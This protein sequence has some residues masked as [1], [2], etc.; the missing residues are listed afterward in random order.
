MCLER[1]I[2]RNKKNAL[3]TPNAREPHFFPSVTCSKAGGASPPHRCHLPPEF[4]PL[5]PAKDPTAP[6]L[7]Y[8][9]PVQQTTYDPC[10]TLLPG[11]LPSLSLG[12]LPYPASRPCLLAT[13]VAD[14]KRRQ[15]FDGGAQESEEA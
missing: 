11:L 9:E 2:L 12:P 3:P 4:A 15:T 14:G 8:V 7:R 5:L 6:C 10:L 1:A 13:F